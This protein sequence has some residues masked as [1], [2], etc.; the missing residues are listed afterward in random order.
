MPELSGAWNTSVMYYG[1]ETVPLAE[2]PFFSHFTEVKDGITGFEL[3]HHVQEGINN[4]P[5]YGWPTLLVNR[6]FCYL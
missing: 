6:G 5:A 2:L 1:N 4:V 3:L